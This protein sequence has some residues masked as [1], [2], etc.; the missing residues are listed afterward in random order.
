MT[1][2]IR[3]ASA[4][5]A[6]L[7]STLNTDV[8]AIHAE[9]LPWRFKPPGPESFPPA[10][11]V[12]LLA[13]PETIV[14]IATV[15]LFPAGYAYAEVMRL[16]ETPFRHAYDVVHVHHISVRPQYR[17]KGVGDALLAA[18]RSAGN[19]LGI[20]LLTLDVWTFNDGARAFFRR[21][22][23]TSYIERLWNRP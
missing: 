21:Q 1:I 5:D 23:F 10:A 16:P 6:A 7:V 19:A 14:F 3:R 9:A 17:R 2:E 20:G 18:M 8:Q 13:K 22:G 11:A 12:E 4:A 15:D